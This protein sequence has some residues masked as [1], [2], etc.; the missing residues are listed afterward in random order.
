MHPILTFGAAYGPE[1]ASW[2]L[3]HRAELGDAY[4][5]LARPVTASLTDR[6]ATIDRIGSVLVSQQNGQREVLGLLHQNTAKLD[7]ISVAVENVGTAQVALGHSIDALTTLSMVG[8]GVSV[9]SQVHIAI[10]FA[11]LTRRIKTIDR[12]VKAIQEMLL[13]QNR[14]EL[15][16]GLDE[17]HKAGESEK[18]DVSASQE[19]TLGARRN[20]A[21]SRASDSEQLDG[22]L[23][24][25]TP[26]PRH[27]W[28]LARHLT[29]AVLGEA[30][31]LLRMNLPE[32]AIASLEDGLKTLRRHAAVVF[33]RT[34]A[35]KPTQF[36]MPGLKPSGITLESL[37]ELFRQAAAAGVYQATAPVS[38]VDLFESWREALGGAN[39]PILWRESTL[40]R[41]RTEYA[42]AWAAVEDVN[43]LNGLILAIRTYQS[44]GRSYTDL[45]REILRQIAGQS[46]PD[47]ACL[48]IFPCAAV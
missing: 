37:A 42:E 6:T 20:L 2:L 25:G 13:Q 7:G 38:S 43:R 11:A 33:A 26:D 30:T 35:A 12:G 17:L 18:T 21:M 16:H 10:Q 23:S 1:I 39:D 9:L 40:Q 41:L 14:A 45:M 44:T 5:R 47:G 27:L 24:P 8:L 19:F 48:A 29:T 15:A 31:A 46:F 32:Q 4:E 34:V 22:Q 28:M 3:A 36:L